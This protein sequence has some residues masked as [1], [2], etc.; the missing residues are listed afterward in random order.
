MTGPSLVAKGKT[1][2]K[3]IGRRPMTLEQRVFD[4]FSD[5]R[6]YRGAIWAPWDISTLFQDANGTV[7]VTADGD[8][9]RLMLDVSGNDAHWLAPSDLA[10]P[11]Y[12]GGAQPYLQGNGTSSEMVMVAAGLGITSFANEVS[13]QMGLLAD[14][15]SL[16]RTILFI[17]TSSNN[18]R[19]A[20]GTGASAGELRGRF[21]RNWS[22]TPATDVFL[23][24]PNGAHL[25][26]LYANYIGGEAT[27]TRDV[28]A[29][30]GSSVLPE[31]QISEAAESAGT[32]LF[33]FSG[34]GF[35]N[36]R[37]YGGIILASELDIT[38]QRADI[39]AYLAEKIGI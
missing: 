30:S 15:I 6:A 29:A 2:T 7:P 13:V 19:L 37:F 25:W 26:E 12:K 14:S 8:P 4:F 23:A 28:T 17:R 18:E 16:Y 33:G 35:A 21:R 34:T 24:R 10:R 36:M 11:I 27:L 9:V 38:D 5:K 31:S 1:F 39:A 20:L 3:T 22:D 32:H